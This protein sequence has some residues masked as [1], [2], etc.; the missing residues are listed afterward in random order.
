[1]KINI[2]FRK[3]VNNLENLKDHSF[4]TKDN[5]FIFFFLLVET[6]I[7][8]TVHFLCFYWEVPWKGPHYDIVV[9]KPYYHPWQLLSIIMR[10]V[11]RHQVQ[12]IF[13]INQYINMINLTIKSMN[14]YVAK[15]CCCYIR[16]VVGIQRKLE[17]FKDYNLMTLS[18]E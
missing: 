7:L 4:V 17:W 2:L 8:S 18:S 10:K 16:A 11:F 6:G 9:L 3:K 15:C 1:M 13:T 5:F 14:S 12:S